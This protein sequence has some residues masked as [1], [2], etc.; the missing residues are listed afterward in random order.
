M[1]KNI[2]QDDNLLI[3][4]TATTQTVVTAMPANGPTKIQTSRGV[5]RADNL[6]KLIDNILVATG[7]TLDQLTV[8]IVRRGL[9]SYT[10]LRI[11]VSVAN[12]LAWSLDI[13]VVGILSS[14]Q[15]PL[16][17]SA[18]YQKIHNSSFVIHHSSF[19]GPLV[20]KYAVW[21]KKSNS[22]RVS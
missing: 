3:I 9:G 14:R 2:R 1:T 17:V 7:L 15:T 6:L 10:G 21:P 11:G 22:D 4:D 18:I 12:S 19:T 20:P 13:P 5:A 8:I 16:T